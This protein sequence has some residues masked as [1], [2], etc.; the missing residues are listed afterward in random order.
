MPAKGENTAPAPPNLPEGEEYRSE[1]FS[2]GFS[3]QIYND[4][5]ITFKCSIVC[6]RV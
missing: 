3:E 5:A 2:P 6:R 4:E 1:L